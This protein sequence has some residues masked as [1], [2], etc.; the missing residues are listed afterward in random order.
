M[1]KFFFWALILIV[2]GAMIV[3]LSTS[4]FGEKYPYI[5]VYSPHGKFLEGDVKK[6]FEAAHPGWT[7]RFQD[8]GGGEIFAKIGAER[9][10]PRASVW[11]GG[12]VS[13][14]KNAEEQGLLEP[15][16][17]AWSASLPANAKS[18]TGGWSATF[19]TPEIILYNPNKIKADE[20]PR[21]WDDLLDPK[22]KGRIA[23]R[24]VRA[25]SGMKLIFGALILREKERR[26]SID[27]GFEFLKKLDANTALP[28]AANPD[29]LYRLLESDGPCVLAPWNLPDVLNLKKN[30]GKPFDYI[31]PTNTMVNV[32][33]IALIKNGPNPEGAKLFYDFVN[34]P[35][36]LVLM[37][38]ERDRIPAR[39]DI[40][41]E[42]LPE[43]MRNLK[44][45][46]MKF[47]A[48]EFD[49]NIE[50][51]MARWDAEIKGKGGR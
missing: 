28:Y 5:D 32:E 19:L 14:F 27:A 1:R 48:K 26:G 7:L 20:L 31:L 4:D 8:M 9:A 15:Y 39:T 21:E 35:E 44:L 17:P 3:I 6:R 36:Q 43:A 37:A 12:S 2:V 45:D 50:E 51:W 41:R 18:P 10:Q 16:F 13:D 42:K 33:P 23:V 40:L 47:D 29:G 38:H 11:W 25:S 30:K 24:D 22:W 46:P 49:T 34:D